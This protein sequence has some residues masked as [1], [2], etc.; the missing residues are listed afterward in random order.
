MPAATNRPNTGP[1]MATA[2][3]PSAAAPARPS[4]PS[5]TRTRE[6]RAEQHVRQMP[7]GVR[8]VQQR[9][10]IAPT[11]GPQRVERGAQSNIARDRRIALRRAHDDPAAEAH[12]P[13]PD[14]AEAGV[15]PVTLD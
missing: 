12:A 11:P 1:S 2:A 5:A 9:P 10:V 6:G 8:R 15:A 13:R 14:V 4:A 7:R 3:M